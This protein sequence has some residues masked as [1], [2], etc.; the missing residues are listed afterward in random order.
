ML[1]TSLPMS[2]ILYIWE[3]TEVNSNPESCCIASRRAFNLATHLPSKLKFKKFPI[4]FVLRTKRWKPHNFNTFTLITF[5]EENF[6]ATY[7]NGFKIS[8]KF[9]VFLIHPLISRT[10]FMVILLF[11]KNKVKGAQ[12]GSK[13]LK[14]FFVT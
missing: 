12:N 8:I 2:P 10:I 7:F 5:I 9:R 1:A 11:A 13:K 3:I 14:I 4:T 6:F